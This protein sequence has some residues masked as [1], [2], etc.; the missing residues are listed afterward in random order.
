MKIIF[1]TQPEVEIGDLAVGDTFIY[2]DE[3]FMTTDE[4]SFNEETGKCVELGSGS[5]VN[6]S[7]NK[8]VFKVNTFLTV[9]MKGENYGDKN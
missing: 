2:F 9:K 4:Y 1:E 7:V 5:L 3:I 6:F 8:K